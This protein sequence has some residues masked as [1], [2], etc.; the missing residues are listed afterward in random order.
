MPSQPQPS[1]EDLIRRASVCITAIEHLLDAQPDLTT[2][3]ATELRQA[4]AKHLPASTPNP[5]T[6]YLNEYV[7]DTASQADQDSTARTPRITRATA[8]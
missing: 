6:V 7:Y 1:T 3:M 5:D 2:V 4:L 8:A